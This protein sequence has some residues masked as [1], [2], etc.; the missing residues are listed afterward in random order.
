[1]LQAAKEKKDQVKSMMGMGSN[2]RRLMLD[3][4]NKVTELDQ[5]IDKA[6][7]LSKQM[8][9]TFKAGKEY[10]DKIDSVYKPLMSLMGWR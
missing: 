2:K 5:N 1:M 8:T 4:L 7:N 9:E 6:Y 10:S 3:S